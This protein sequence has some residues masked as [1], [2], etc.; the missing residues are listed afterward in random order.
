[1]F[2][3]PAPLFEEE[4]YPRVP[5]LLTQRSRPSRFE[6]TSSRA[7][8]TTDNHPIDPIQIYGTYVFDKR[9]DG[10]KLN[11]STGPA[12]LSDAGHAVFFVLYTDSPPN[13]S[14]FSGKL[15]L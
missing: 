12:Q 9:L 13:I 14:Q 15:Q 1:M 8:L 4:L 11:C 10:Q 2:P 6:R 7:T 5:A 3:N